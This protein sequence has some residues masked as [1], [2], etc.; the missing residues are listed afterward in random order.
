VGVS[1]GLVSWAAR[2]SMIPGC[3][4]EPSCVYA[5][6]M[7]SWP[8]RFTRCAATSSMSSGLAN[9]SPVV[10]CAGDDTPGLEA[11]V[12]DVV[13]DAGGDGVGDAGRPGEVVGED[14]QD[15]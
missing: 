15:T 12:G 5:R 3:K 10:T 14:G 8:R 2:E 11:A 9:G 7:S 6:P 1:W 4:G 13:N